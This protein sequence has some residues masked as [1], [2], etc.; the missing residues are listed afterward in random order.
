MK[1]LILSAVM[2]SMLA[3]SAFSGQAA[4]LNQPSAMQSNVIQVDWHKPVVV[5]KKVVVK[6]TV[7]VK[8]SHW[9]NGQRY[10]AWKRHQ[11]VRDWNRYGLRRPGPGQE[12]IRVGNDYLLVGI[13]S[14][15]I[16]GAI[17]AH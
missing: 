15:V 10:A 16:F 3:A 4:P 1:R 9:R 12:W 8:R 11:A 13:V 7:V 5:K 17:A 14:G 2:A 6:R